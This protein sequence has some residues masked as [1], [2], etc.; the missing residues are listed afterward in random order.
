MAGV[1]RGGRHPAV[2]DQDHLGALLGGAIATN[3]RVDN[4]LFSHELFGV[5]LGLVM[6]GGIWCRDRR[7]RALIP[8]AR[9]EQRPKAGWSR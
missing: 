5:Y 6:W 2:G 9:E 3:V 4:P 1:S 7:L 8:Q